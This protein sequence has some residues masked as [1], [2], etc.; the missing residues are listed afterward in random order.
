MV[1]SLM[2]NKKLVSKALHAYISILL[3]FQHLPNRIDTEPG[4][5]FTV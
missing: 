5:I 4:L 2:M 1:A 3:T